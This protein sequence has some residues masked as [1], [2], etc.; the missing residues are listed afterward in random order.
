MCVLR[1]TRFPTTAWLLSGQVQAFAEENQKRSKIVVACRIA[2][3]CRWFCDIECMGQS[4][5]CT[6]RTAYYAVSFSTL[7][8]EA[9]RG[10]PL[11]G[12]QSIE[13]NAHAQSSQTKKQQQRPSLHHNSEDRTARQPITEFQS[14]GRPL[15]QVPT[16]TARQRAACSNESQ[17]YELTI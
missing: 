7:D 4:C 3:P 17:C 14:I 8:K 10:S 12:D 13:P 16:L 5:C 1:S 9:I 15:V 11:L 6:F 2:D